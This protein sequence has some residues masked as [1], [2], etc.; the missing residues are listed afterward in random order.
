[1]S[2]TKRPI[3]ITEALLTRLFSWQ[4]ELEL[5]K[6]SDEAAVNLWKQ[7]LLYAYQGIW[8][9]SQESA[10]RGERGLK[11]PSIG[12]RSQKVATK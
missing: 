12:G 5:K 2:N 1:M 6:A 3:I 7:S 4:I 11:L 8:H 10:E 9:C